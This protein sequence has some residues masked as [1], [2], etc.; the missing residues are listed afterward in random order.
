MIKKG[1]A[2]TLFVTRVRAD[3]PHHTVPAN[4]LAVFTESFD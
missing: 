2:L 4:N 3:D 1:L